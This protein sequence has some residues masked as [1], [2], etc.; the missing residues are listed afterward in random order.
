MKTKHLVFAALFTALIAVGAQI[1]IP[2]GPIPFTLQVP[3]V[4]LAGMLLGKKLGLISITAYIFIG[5]I[6]IP[7]FAGAGGLGSLVSPSFGFVLGFI[8]GVV[9]TAVGGNEH[10]GRMITFTLL[11]MVTI[12]M[13]CAL[14]RVYYEYGNRN[15]YVSDG[16]LMAAV[17]PFLIKDVILA[18]LTVMFAKT[19]TQR[20]LMLA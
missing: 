2:L 20:G 15:S 14:F 6:G 12:Y 10:A 9:I 8:P 11:G 7:V 17:V 5:L 13:R 1:R 16:I 18:V 4:L 19:L 3:M